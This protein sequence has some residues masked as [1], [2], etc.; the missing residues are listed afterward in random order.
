M[1]SILKK[2]FP[3]AVAILV[4]F[5]ANVLFFFPQIEGKVLKQG[6]IVSWNASAQE[7]MDYNNTHKD[8]LLWTNSMFGGMPSYQTS[9]IPKGNYLQYVY[10]VLSMNVSTPIGNFFALMIAYYFMLIILGVPTFLSIAGALAF[11]FTTNNFILFEAGHNSKLAVMVFFPLIISGLFLMFYKKRYLF[12]A[13]LFGLG[14][15]ANIGANHVQMTYYFALCLIP[16][17]I[18]WIVDSTLTKQWK[19]LLITVGLSLA[20][21]GVALAANLSLLWPTYEYSQETMRGKPILSTATSQA[22]SAS[23][24]STSDGLDFAYAMQWSNGLTDLI[25]AIIPRAVGGGSGELINKGTTFTAL[26]Q[27]GSPRNPDGSFSLPM[28]WG[29]LPFTSGPAYFGAVICFLFLFAAFLVKGSLKW[30]AVGAV[31]LTGLLSMGDNAASFQRLF[32]DYFPLYNKFRT[33]NS[34]LTITTLFLPLLG[35]YGLSNVLRRQYEVKDVQ[36]ALFISGG[37]TGG[38]ALIIAL[39]GTSFFSFTGPADASLQPELV[40]LLMQ[41]RKT[42]LT[43]DAWRSFLLIAAAFLVI[44]GY[45]KNWYSATVLMATISVLTIFD[46]WGVGRRYLQ[47]GNFV[48]ETNYKAQFEPRQVDQE[49]LSLEKSRGNYRV[50]DITKGLTSSSMSS[51]YHNTIGGY[52]PAKLQRYQDLIDFQINKNNMGVFNM[53]NTK[54]II[55]Q[56]GKLQTNPAALGPAWFVDSIVLVN[57][58]DE[59]MKALD[60]LNTADVAVVLD[61]EFNGY[62]GNFNPQKAGTISLK[63]YD[64]QHLVYE[65]NAPTE[66]FAVFSEIWYGPNK[67]WEA[68]IDGKIVD[69]VRT[70]Y[71]LRALRVPA[72]KHTVELVFKPRSVEVAGRISAIASLLLLLGFIGASGYGIWNWSKHP[73]FPEKQPLA[74]TQPA[75][76]VRTPTTTAKRKHK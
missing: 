61:R 73:T 18:A 56:D 50:L 12:G 26:V 69:L 3:H 11:G 62:V 64:P 70:N 28:Y 54:Y 2:A 45:L 37:I 58:P 53:L 10:T 7:I 52:H 29:D 38:I 25:A 68:Y 55:T 63:T 21:L 6:D 23:S 4:L 22:A 66:Q 9:Y 67:G 5:L 57:T 14:L 30:W 1:N 16:L 60:S 43:N 19:S 71:V 59:E 31:I 20:F 65:T 40:T 74:P 24:S 42:L 34:I 51:Y 39:M 27:A 17:G 36:K 33:P 49:I 44:W 46:L 8:P 41:D 35:L 48:S 75:E 47:P 72:G 15:G 32:F 13:V 76:P